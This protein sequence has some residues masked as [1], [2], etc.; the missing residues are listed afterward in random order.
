MNDNGNGKDTSIDE[1]KKQKELESHEKQKRFAEHPENFIEL[2]DIIVCS[3]R[4]PQ[5]GLGLSVYIG[6]CKRSELDI[7]S[8]ELN[9][10]INK[11]LIS[12]D[13]ESEMKVQSARNM[14]D[15][16]AKPN[17]KGGLKRFLGR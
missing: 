15:P 2:S 7:T 13:I 14:L 10:V 17:F 5:S 1:I 12:M 16:L 6:N 8:T 9:H 3:I 11:R 4:N